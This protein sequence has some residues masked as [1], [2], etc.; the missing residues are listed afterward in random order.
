MIGNVRC[1]AN[2]SSLFDCSYET[3]AHEE[4]S[5]CDPNQVAAVACLGIVA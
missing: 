4:V 5:Q 1:G 2:E 3:S